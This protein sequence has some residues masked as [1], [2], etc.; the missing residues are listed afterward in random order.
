V[1]ADGLAEL[2][3]QVRHS[4]WVKDMPGLELAACGLARQLA[5]RRQAITQRA[6]QLAAP[7]VGSLPRTV[8][9][10][11]ALQAAQ[12]RAAI[13]WLPGPTHRARPGSTDGADAV[14]DTVAD[15]LR[16][17][18]SLLGAPGAEVARIMTGS[19]NLAPARVTDRLRMSPIP[20]EPMGV[21]TVERVADR[22]LPGLVHS[23][24]PEVLG[25]TPVL[26]TH[27]CR[28]AD[29]S[30]ALLRVRRPS[31]RRAL[32]SDARFTGTLAWTASQLV[33][34]LRDAHPQGFVE[35]TVRQ[36]LDSLDLRNHA[37]N[38]IELGLAV[39]ALD[40]QG[41]SVARPVPGGFAAA[42]ALFEPVDGEP[43]TSGSAPG[44]PGTVG[45]ALASVLVLA[46]IGR[47]VFLAEPDPQFQLRGDGDTTTFVGCPVLGRLTPILR[48]SGYDFLTAVLSG[49]HSGQ[50]A[51]MSAAGA[52]P[53]GTDTDALIA[54]LAA[55]DGLD[56]MALLGSDGPTALLGGLREAV[57][58]LLR[59][60]LRPPLEVV[61]LM[62][63]LFALQEALPVA[64]PGAT[65][66]GSL[67]PLLPRLPELAHGS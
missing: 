60:R 62:R 65:L 53:E 48:T 18:L 35:L 39:E 37:L 45:T 55:A 44:D 34:G 19:G 3:Q 24:S 56:P 49:D 16:D 57:T 12:L 47:G 36:L 6:E 43:V 26:Q 22:A 27:R 67:L 58:V 32:L 59:H 17:H 11:A 54:D 31:A 42:A 52:V 63:G 50:V 64:A 29:G 33:P 8:H 41:V 21:D 5:P 7:G 61:L 10:A 66:T 15:V 23:V 25:A 2:T 46:A 13:G 40:I 14:K 28:L 4:Q 51:A 9:Q 30:A 20:W 1:I 38:A